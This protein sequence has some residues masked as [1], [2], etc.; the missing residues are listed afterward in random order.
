MPGGVGL[1]AFVR[2]QGRARDVAAQ[3]LQRLAIIGAAAHGCV[4]AETL[5]VGAQRL[6]K[7]IR[8]A[9]AADVW[10]WYLWNLFLALIPLALSSWMASATTSSAASTWLL[11]VVFLLWLLFFFS[12]A[13]YLVTDVVH[14]TRVT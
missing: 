7:A 13:P 12:N 11:S 3:L 2:S 10:D 6:L 14:L 8:R 5:D 1:H 4:Q 9:S